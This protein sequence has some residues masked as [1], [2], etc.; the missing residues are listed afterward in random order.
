MASTPRVLDLAGRAKRTNVD[1]IG[2]RL[3]EFL[4]GMQTFTLE[5]SAHTFDVGPEWFDRVRAA[6]GKDL[7][8][9]VHR[10]GS[11]PWGS[12]LAKAIVEQWP[13]DIEG[14]IERVDAVQPEDLWLLFA[15]AHVRPLAD[16]VARDVFVRA[17]RGDRAA[18]KHLVDEAAET[19]GDRER[20]A[21]T[22]SLSAEELHNLAVTALRGWYRDVFSSQ[23]QH[24][25]QVIERDV[26]AK[27]RL[28]RTL[29]DAELIEAASNG[30][31]YV[32][33]PWVEHI[34]L[35]P[36][37]AMRPWNVS[38]AHDDTYV[39]CYPV[40]DE[41]IGLDQGAPPA[42]LVRLHKALADEKRLRILKLLA[43]SDLNLQ[44]L[45][46]AIGLGKSTTHHHTVILRSAGL[47]RTST[48]LENRY[49]IRREALA[50]A[51]AALGDFLEGETP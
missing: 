49:S 40:A 25:T 51:G 44:E 39:L 27:E 20:D 31:V 28:R 42:H 5:E 34:V 48:E 17:A 14:C 35:T 21:G 1:V 32:P 26:A 22:W 19:F 11:A 38:C 2:T 37:L 50:E 41:S 4:I 6:A 24:A 30:L 15:G 23:E 29:S 33:E 13:D 46:A 3:T 16:R 8:P 45:S 7:S 9:A 47:I 43:R 12:L 10:L 18:R 36:H